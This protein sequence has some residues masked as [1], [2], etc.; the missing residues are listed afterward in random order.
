MKKLIFFII[1]SDLKKF[2]RFSLGI[3]GLNINEI[4]IYKNRLNYNFK[5]KDMKNLK[6]FLT[7]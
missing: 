7:Y 1:P 4:V 6:K 5:D 3:N 2:I